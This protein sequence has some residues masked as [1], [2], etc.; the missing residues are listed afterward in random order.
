[1]SD[2]QTSR[3][4]IFSKLSFVRIGI[5][6]AIAALAIL[7]L[8]V[9][10]ASLPWRS[11]PENKLINKTVTHVAQ[12]QTVSLKTI[13]AQP[14]TR[15][16]PLFFMQDPVETITTYESDCV[17]PSSSFEL[18]DTVC[19]KITGTPG[20]GIRRIA[21]LNGA[22]YIVADATV[23]TEGQTLS[24]ALPG[25]ATSALTPDLTV[26]NRGKWHGLSVG[27]GDGF[28]RAAAPFIVTDPAQAVADVAIGDS[29]QVEVA[30][31]V[32][33][34]VF[35]SNN[36]P[37]TATDV[38]ITD[39]VPA[40]ATFDSVDHGP[41]F[42]CAE[43]TGTVTCE[44]GSLASG[45][46]KELTFVY[47]VAGA[48]AGTAITHS[49]AIA[50]ATT[51]NYPA[52]NVSTATEVID[53]AGGGA[54]VCALDCPDDITV[55]ANA[56]QG[57]NPG[58]F[59][60]FSSA[61]GIGT[62]GE[63]S[64]SV[65]SGSFFSLGTTTVVVTSATGGGSCDFDV[66]VVTGGAPT[67]TCPANQTV[68]AAVGATEAT[69]D[70]GTPT[71]SPEMGVS[72]SGVRSDDELLTA[73][74]PI[75][76]THITWTVTDSVGLSSSC[77]QLITV[78]SNDCATDTTPPTITAPADVNLST[79]DGVVGSCGLVVG[80]S[81]LGTA[82]VSDNC[83]V[84]VVRTG[85]P[86]GNFFPVGPTT[87]TYTATDSAGNTVSDTQVVTI[88]DGSAPSIAAP[89][90]ASYVC[91][92]EVPAADP[93]Q[94]TRGEVLDENG[95]PL[96]PGPP[97]D[98]CGTPIV[99]VSETSTGAGS[100]SSP[101]IITRTF[102]ATDAAGNSASAVQTITVID[103]VNPTITGPAD[104]TFECVGEVPAAN[105]SDATASDNCAPP[106]VT[107]SDS[108]NGGAGTTA[109][110]L[111]ITRTF[112][113]TDA[114]GNT[115]QDAQIITVIDNTAP[116]I[117]CPAPIVLEPTCPSGAIANWTEPVGT[118]NCPGAITTRTG[119]APGSVF[120]VG[121]TT[122]TYTVN[123]AHGN[124]ASCNFTVTVLTAQQVVQNLID[125]VNALPGLTGQQRQGLLS[126]LTAV[127]DAINEGKTNVACNK[128]SDFIS[129]VSSYINNGTLTSAQGQPLIDSAAHV[130][131]YLGCTSLPC[132]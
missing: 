121:T 46:T 34:T 67:I 79:P 16:A 106:T 105:P 20:A 119:P 52:N 64:S 127:L 8:T 40:G 85:V 13:S 84:N 27:L 59:V 26:D 25:T 66:T 77:T 28:T 86:A 30:S 62:C 115:A 21:F 111:I 129:Q 131:N 60:T 58:A 48:T 117:S 98:N 130:R 61:E 91:P 82:E 50:S 78:N 108:G 74:Y 123:D 92:S 9:S 19:I 5:F 12:G 110:P 11:N 29:S 49:P 112:T 83:T 56:T 7:P 1:M 63:I 33:F 69:V 51:D 128:L 31:T 44:L 101:L 90:D 100:A 97:V 94:A 102:T 75:G 124:S 32:R 125:A 45:A 15:F 10:S 96:P 87:I 42:T 18:G 3:P 81:S 39:A 17:T 54:E 41:E 122:V 88:T 103:A 38:E 37:Q 114:A 22:N 23:N 2:R 118:D 76:T 116:A 126:K 120:P 93:S 107:V 57:G 109:S 71:T 95:N 113:A 99:T 72:V 47:G 24:F 43:D 55:V 70:P 132:S 89:P 80:E 4:R 35:V 68:T 53:A 73:P 14:T 65:A 6:I 36:G 104:A